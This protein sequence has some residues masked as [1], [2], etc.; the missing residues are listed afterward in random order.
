[1]YV[2]VSACQNK[3][4]AYNFAIL[5]TG[6]LHMRCAQKLHMTS[7]VSTLVQRDK[8]SKLNKFAL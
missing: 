8:I 6:Y 7:K 2:L 4:E 3:Q 5:R 1:M